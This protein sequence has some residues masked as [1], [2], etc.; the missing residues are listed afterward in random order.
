MWI[1]CRQNAP[2]LFSHAPSEGAELD[3]ILHR[4]PAGR[5]LEALL[6]NLGASQRRKLE[7]MDRVGAG[8][9]VLIVCWLSGLGRCRIDRGPTNRTSL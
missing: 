8:L 4:S 7:I 6:H 3:K 1:Q 2:T 5:L 9:L